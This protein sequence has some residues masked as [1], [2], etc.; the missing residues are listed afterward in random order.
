MPDRALAD[1]RMS[2]GFRVG[3]SRATSL[4]GARGNL[5]SIEANPAAVREYIEEELKQSTIRPA[6]PEES[7]HIS[8]IGLIPKGGQTRKFRLIVDL[9][10]PH[11]ASINDG[12]DPKLCS[13]S[14][15]SPLPGCVNAAPGF[16][17][18]AGSTVSLPEGSGTPGRS[19]VARQGLR[20]PD[21]L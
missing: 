15:S 17:G 19:A 20:G 16:D 3:F 7:V 5:P 11:G 18:E 13:L 12:I 21:L 8:P 6:L 10:S 2:L 14:Y 9:S 4:R 1:F